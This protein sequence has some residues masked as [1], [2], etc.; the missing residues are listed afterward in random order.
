[1]RRHLY[2]HSNLPDHLGF[3]S[4]VSA[5]HI[6][7]KDPKDTTTEKITEFT[8]L[9]PKHHWDL[10]LK[11]VFR[12]N[13]LYFASLIMYKDGLYL[14]MIFGHYFY[15]FIV[16]VTVVAVLLLYLFLVCYF[17]IIIIIIII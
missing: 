7:K 9:K 13:L 12:L 1:M 14:K 3:L 8:P 16:S 4:D 2:E 17:V 6:D 15:A 10:I 11:M 5:T